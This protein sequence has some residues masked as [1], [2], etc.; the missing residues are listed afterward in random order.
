MTAF[1]CPKCEGRMP[2]A[3]Q[4]CPTCL[5][6]VHQDKIKQLVQDAEV[7]TVANQL[8][9]AASLW[10]QVLELI[11]ADVLQAQLVKERLAVLRERIDGGEN[12]TPAPTPVAAAGPPDAPASKGGLLG[13]LA[14]SLWKFKAAILFALSK[15]K[16]LMMGLSKGGT[17]FTMLFTFGIYW[18]MW[19]WQFALGILVCLYIHEM[20]H[21]AALT[22]YG[23]KAT[24]PMFYPFLGAIIRL[25]QYPTDPVEDARIGLAGP[26]WGMGASMFCLVAYMVTGAKV[27][28]AIA[29]V[30]A[31]INLF[32]LIPWGQLDGGRGFRALAR[33]QRI[34]VALVAAVCWTTS[35]D[36]L[37]LV[38]FVVAGGRAIFQE[39][40]REGEASA[41]VEFTT[42]LVLLTALV[43]LLKV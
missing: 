42:L 23:I 8:S 20:G 28:A 38:I 24:A 5:R 10:R 19:G 12:D 32:N 13:I 30:S 2:P 25:N 39:A 29:K 37:L 43:G 6:F 4:V 1:V 33:W 22:R 31:W 21:V 11:P 17:M 27:W 3:L 7:A 9:H 16:F 26:L 18:K 34:G 14:L 35:E 36:G 15:A 40:P 41:F